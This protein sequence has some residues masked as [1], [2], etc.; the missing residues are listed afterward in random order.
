METFCWGVIRQSAVKFCP[1]LYRTLAL[2]EWQPLP[3][4]LVHL[5]LC[6]SYQARHGTVNKLP[7]RAEL[8]RKHIQHV[9]Q[10]QL[11]HLLS[12]RYCR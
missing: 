4:T 6:P 3:Q 11:Q 8:K 1:P 12:C 10:E 7:G 9:S 2:N 5:T